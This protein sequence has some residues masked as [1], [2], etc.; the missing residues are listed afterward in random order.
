MASAKEVMEPLSGPGVAHSIIQL[1]S[2]LEELVIKCRESFNTSRTKDDASIA[3]VSMLQELSNMCDLLRHQLHEHLESRS[4]YDELLINVIDRCDSI[5]QGLQIA[6]ARLHDERGGQQVSRATSTLV[7]EG[8]DS[9]D[10]EKSLR[11]I[12]LH[13]SGFLNP[14]IKSDL[15]SILDCHQLTG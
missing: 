14:N 5:C 12:R 10:L 7:W 6:L 15:L 4:K 1:V 13:L 8:Q 2:M 11:R 9:N 3:I